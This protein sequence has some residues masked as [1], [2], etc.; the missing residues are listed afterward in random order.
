MNHLFTFIAL[1]VLLT[2]TRHPEA[3]AFKPSLTRRAFA[4]ATSASILST[5]LTSSATAA[6][7]P[8]TTSNSVNQ[9]KSLLSTFSYPEP[10]PFVLRNQQLKIGKGE[11]PLRGAGALVE[12]KK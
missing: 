2:T 10:E 5:F 1:L 3:Y 11:K 7:P 8:T 4:S 9:E 6:P 12:K